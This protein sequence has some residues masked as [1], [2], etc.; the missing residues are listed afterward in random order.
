[1]KQLHQ[2]SNGTQFYWDPDCMAA[3][4]RVFNAPKGSGIYQLRNMEVFWKLFPKRAGLVIDIGAHIGL[5]TVHYSKR[6]ETV[7]AFEALPF[8]FELLEENIKVNGCTNVLTMNVALGAH[9]AHVGLKRPASNT[10]TTHV[11]LTGTGHVMDSGD[12]ILG[13][14][15]GMP[16][17]DYIKMDTEGSEQNILKGLQSTI[18]IHRPVMQIELIDKHLMRYGYD[19]AHV[20]GW[21]IAMGY[22]PYFYDG[23]IVSIEDYPSGMRPTDIFFIPADHKEAERVDAMRK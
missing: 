6:A 5:N 18:Y 22:K 11:D 15:I 12:S 4:G 7:I 8:N 1:M 13:D 10:G 9:K 2:F 19:S 3:I 21:M 14:L 16:K 23:S 17:L 20:I